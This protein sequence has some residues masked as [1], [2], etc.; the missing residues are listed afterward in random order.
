MNEAGA[1]YQEWMKNEKDKEKLK[2]FRMSKEFKV[3]GK[4]FLA[5][6]FLSSYKASKVS[7]T[8]DG[9]N[10]KKEDLFTKWETTVTL[11]KM[12][13]MGRCNDLVRGE[14]DLYRIDRQVVTGCNG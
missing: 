8:E 3:N 13:M 1:K 4:Q 2:K 10:I 6:V 9:G 11:E 12:L 14:K 7:K 5:D